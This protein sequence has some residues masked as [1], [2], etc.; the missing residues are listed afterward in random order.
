MAAL[1]TL[2]AVAAAVEQF[3][4]LQE[5]TPQAL[6]EQ[7]AMAMSSSSQCKENQ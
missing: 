7:V 5:A 2:A 4:D 6:A 1:A 3:L